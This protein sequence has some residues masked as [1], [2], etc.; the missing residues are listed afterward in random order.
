ME[1]CIQFVVSIDTK[2]IVSP[3]FGIP[4]F[5]KALSEPF[6]PNNGETSKLATG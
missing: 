5:S 4:P 3:L 1:Q 2:H 6:E